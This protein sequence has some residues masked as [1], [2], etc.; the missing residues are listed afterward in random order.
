P[1]SVAMVGNVL[2]FSADL[3]SGFTAQDAVNL[4]AADPV[5]STQFV[6]Q[7]DTDAEPGNDGSGNL[8]AAGPVDFS[9]GTSEVLRG[10]DVHRQETDGLFSALVRLRKA[11]DDGNLL[12]GERAV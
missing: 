12:D 5:L 8:A 10:N 9:G 1:A 2:T 6:A 11:L 3:A 4:L 7:L